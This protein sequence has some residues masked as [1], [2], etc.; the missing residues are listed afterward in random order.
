MKGLTERRF[1]RYLEAVK[2]P[3]TNLVKL[4]FLQPDG[5]VAFSLD[6]TYKRGYN[7]KY[8]S[9]A[10]IQGGSV[11]SAL[12]NGMRRQ[13]GITLANTDGAF[14]YAIN[15][16]WFGQ[17]V[18]ISM[19][20]QFPDG[21]TF[22]LPQGVYY[23]STPQSIFREN[24]KTISFSLVDK[25][26]YLD[27]SLFGTLD[28][29]YVIPRDTNI[30]KAIEDILQISKF[31][32]EKTAKIDC[33][34]DSVKPIFTDFYNG[35]TYE[36]ANSDGSITRNVSMTNT[37]YEITEPGGGTF[38]NLILSLNQIL[39]GII[40]YDVT[41]AL[42]LEP[43]QD[44]VLDVSKPILYHF[45]SENSIFSSLSETVNN[46]AV[47]NDVYVVGEGLTGASVWGRAVNLDSRSVTSVQNLKKRNVL[48]LEKAEYWNTQQCADLAVWTLKRKSVLSRSISISCAPLYHLRENA[49][50]S[51]KRGDK[52]GTPVEKH[53]I[54]SYT[55]PLTEAGNMTINAVSTEDIPDFTVSK[56]VSKS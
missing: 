21:E 31:D 30:Y 56:S 9:R 28:N 38:G 40:G 23:I 34:I 29:S 5:S 36:A 55:L 26:A 4:D 24:Q 3:H 27:G 50:I 17:Q 16:I 41:G 49:L 13:A 2:K 42:R 37:P 10:F 32:F 22:Y 11:S 53:L 12:Q 6:N 45:S 39:V 47:Y 20:L 35:K 14:D 19:G 54:Q 46:N 48:R 18:K 33:M 1:L 15:K 52:E 8:D 43:S 44:D 7:T 25:W 51:V